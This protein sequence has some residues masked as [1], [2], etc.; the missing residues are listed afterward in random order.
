MHHGTQQRGIA[1]LYSLLVI[2]LFTAIA[3]TI[4]V[5][6]INELKLTASSTD[7]TVAY[8]AAE[9]GIERGLHTVKLARADSTKTLQ[10]AIDEVTALSADLDGSNADYT[11]EDSEKE[12]AR[13]ENVEVMEYEYIQADYYDVSSPLIPGAIVTTLDILNGDSVTNP[14]PTSYAEVSW[15][16]WDEDGLLESSKSARKVIG[17]TDLE[18]G[19]TIALAAPYSGSFVPVGYRIRVKALLGDLTDVT[20]TPRDINGDL[21]GDDDLPSQL[22]I[23]SIGTYRNFRQSLTA[24]IPWK[25]PLYGL[26]DY[27]L[28]S[29][30]N[31]LKD[32]ILSAPTYS[33]GVIQIEAD[34]T[35]TCDD[36][37]LTA[38][39]CGAAGATCS[40]CD[41]LAESCSIADI[42]CTIVAAPAASYCNLPAAGDKYYTLPIPESIPASEEYYLSLRY[43]PEA[44]STGTLEI[45]IDDP[46]TGELGL[47]FDYSDE[48]STPEWDACTVAEPFSLSSELDRNITYTNQD[49]G[50][51]IDLDWYQVSSYK[52]FKDCPQLGCIP[53]CSIDTECSNDW[54]SCQV[55]QCVNAGTCGTCGLQ[56]VTC[57]NNNDGYCP[58]NNCCPS[59]PDCAAPVP[60]DR[61]YWRY[62][63]L[64]E[65]EVDLASY[66]PSGDPGK[67]IRPVSV[68]SDRTYNTTFYR[69]ISAADENNIWVAGSGGVIAWSGDGGQTWSDHDTGGV[70]EN[71][72]GIW[73]YKEG[74][75]YVY[76][77]VGDNGIIIHCVGNCNS[78]SPDLEI[79]VTGNT[80]NAVSGADMDSVWA[81]GD[82]GTILYYT[83]GSWSD[84]SPGIN[85][86]ALRGAWAYSTGMVWAV[87]DDGTILHCDSEANCS[88]ASWYQQGAGLSEQLLTGIDGVYTG[89]F[90]IWIS[91]KNPEIS[92][93]LTDGQSVLH[94]SDGLNW[95]EE[96]LNTGSLVCLWDVGAFVDPQ[97]DVAK[98]VV[99]GM[100]SPYIMFFF[101]GAVWHQSS[102][103]NVAM[104]VRAIESYDWQN[105]WF[106]GTSGRVLY[107]NAVY[108]PDFITIGDDFEQYW[109]SEQYSSVSL[110]AGDFTVGIN[111]T[112][113]TG[114]NNAK[115]KFRMS[116]GYCDDSGSSGGICNDS[117]DFTTW[118]EL[119]G[120][121]DHEIAGRNPDY[122]EGSLGT[123]L[124]YSCSDCRLWFKLWVYSNTG[125]WINVSVSGR[126]F[127]FSDPLLR[128]SFVSFPP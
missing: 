84:I 22:K 76:W 2:S 49:V 74:S 103:G 47:T 66:P 10:D 55:G 36:C 37:G 29:E 17:P 46:Q 14:D 60:P 50:D 116:M 33:S 13:F 71:L 45:L 110:N 128:N 123:G 42:S 104:V 120:V 39:N 24:T 87:G 67:S 19:W 1:L 62:I 80:L 119:D 107:A 99:A 23:K 79:E 9:S 93:D 16:A 48:D 83:G 70:T 57:D 75:D 98:A 40:D 3:I 4:S 56:P 77:A 51:Y 91:A 30:S 92:C 58:P 117:G 94:S 109:F 6:V 105:T 26:Y 114:G 85:S 90:D 34:A 69:A 20:L 118:P 31:I 113:N 73:A 106:A 7:A 65:N 5:I 127:D 115:V 102:I 28:F 61:E 53:E 97:T 59:D 86:S 82:N 11:D 88:T 21:L 68:W 101:D 126:E 89:N 12:T 112:E 38:N 44:P 18:N 35:Q 81:V 15:T 108:Y 124:A 63:A 100:G 54:A 95:S 52:I 41:W 25:V 64:D 122:Y 96:P 43:R 72:R 125:N 121:I 27:V 111:I 32:I 78:A 8:Y